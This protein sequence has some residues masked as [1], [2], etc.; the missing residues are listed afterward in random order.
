MIEKLVDQM[1][2]QLVSQPEA[3]MVSSVES[4]GKCVISIRVAPQD[5]A[6]V[7]GSEGRIFRALKTVVTLVGAR[8][9]RDVVL[10]IAK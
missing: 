1:V 3:V 10:D 5:I 2:R 9:Q 4:D 8:Q 6:R 7:I